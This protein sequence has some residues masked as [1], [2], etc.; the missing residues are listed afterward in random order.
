[1]QNTTR[2]AFL[3]LGAGM[4]TG[5]A[6]AACSVT[7]AGGSN[8][9]KGGVVTLRYWSDAWFPSSITGR[10]QTVEKFNRE[11]KGRIE[12]QYVQGDWDSAETYLQG[13]VAAHGGI[14]DIMETDVQTALTWYQKGWIKDLKPYLTDARKK[15]TLPDVWKARTFPSGGLVCTATVLSEPINVMVYNP[16]HFEA[17]GIEPATID[18]TWDW[19]ELYSNARKL[20][21]D[22]AGHRFGDPGFD[23]AK[24]KQWGYL[25]RLDAEKVWEYGLRFAQWRMGKP[26]IRQ[27]NGVWGWYLDDAGAAVY[28]NFLTAV[29]KGTSPKYA[30]GITGDTQQ[31]AFADGKA[32]ITPAEMFDI[33]V[34]QDTYKH[35]TFSVMPTIMTK[36]DTVSWEASETGEGMVIPKTTKHV[37]EAAEFAF[38]VMQPGNLVDYAYGNGMLPADFKSLDLGKFKTDKDWDIV[39]QYLARGKVFSEPFN[40]NL[41]EF[42]DKVAAPTLLR[43]AAGK[44][45]FASANDFLT[46]QGK[47]LLNK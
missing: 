16:A 45:T 40:P 15:L 7:S 35:F 26:V 27:E 10:K 41:L 18:N 4:A 32:S 44:Q 14:A 20:T 25:P 23:K 38:W 34:M 42:R 1:M 3:G 21:I 22:S 2:R 11:H 6:T 5:M 33:P 17:A 47:S 8:E 9:S 46:K 24:V 43:V 29:Q 37:K 12:V 13:G 30:V 36:S 19:D 39:K 31:Q 28:E